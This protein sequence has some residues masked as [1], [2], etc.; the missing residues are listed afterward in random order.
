[1]LELF[2]G[3]C[4]LG[5]L[6][7]LRKSEWFK[8]SSSGLRSVVGPNNLRQC[9]CPLSFFLMKE[10]LFDACEYDPIGSFNCSV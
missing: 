7:Q 5:S 9:D 10:A 1:M 6:L 4:L 8:P 3:H 2:Q